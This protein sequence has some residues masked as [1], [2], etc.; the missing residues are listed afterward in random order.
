[1]AR[2]V[3]G[4]REVENNNK[5]KKYTYT[6]RPADGKN[7]EARRRIPTRA[8][9]YRSDGPVFLFFSFKRSERNVTFYYAARYALKS[10]IERRVVNKY[11]HSPIT[12]GVRRL[13][14]RTIFEAK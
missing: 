12:A 1:M 13:R 4:A 3:G 14:E 11:V 7:R 8:H 2:T 9:V 5:K 6:E 10:S